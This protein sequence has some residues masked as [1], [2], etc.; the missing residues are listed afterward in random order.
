MSKYIKKENKVVGVDTNRSKRKINKELARFV[1]GD[2]VPKVNEFSKL[3]K[4]LSLPIGTGEFSR[5]FN[6]TYGM[7]IW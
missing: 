6:D 3:D 5:M 4:L 1:D 2:P 7:K